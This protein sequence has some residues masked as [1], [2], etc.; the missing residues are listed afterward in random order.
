MMV[1]PMFDF[2]TACSAARF[3][4]AGVFG[5]N[6]ALWAGQAPGCVFLTF[7]KAAP[8]LD[9]LPPH[10]SIFRTAQYA[11][12]TGRQ[13][14]FGHCCFLFPR[15]SHQGLLDGLMSHPCTP[16][17]H[18]GT[19]KALNDSYCLLLLCYSLYF[20]QGRPAASACSSTVM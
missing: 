11:M 19:R 6:R 7:L 12:Q 4:P 13:P 16:P 9:L 15:K 20:L 2:P 14:Q 17:V 8:P 3:R 18:T 10:V 5:A 1:A